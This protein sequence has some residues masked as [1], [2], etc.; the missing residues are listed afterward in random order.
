MAGDDTTSGAPD[1]PARFALRR[2]GWAWPFMALFAPGD[3]FATVG[4]GAIDVKVGWLGRAHIPIGLVSRVSSMHWPWWGGVGVRIGKKL[5]GFV[6]SSGDAVVLDLS[7]R[8]R[9]KAP[10]GWDTARVVV[11]VTEIERFA[12]AV[13]RE[14]RRLDEER[15]RAPEDPEPPHDA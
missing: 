14:R 4:D 1:A 9:V 6:P 2:S 5:V 13:D 12:A 11:A 8:I 15:A 10:F 7:E 3:H